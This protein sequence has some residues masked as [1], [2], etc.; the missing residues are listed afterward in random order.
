MSLGALVGSSLL[1]GF[2]QPIDQNMDLFNVLGE[3]HFLILN[4]SFMEYD[5]LRVKLFYFVAF[6]GDTLIKIFK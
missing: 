3:L 2:L 4:Y 5:A 1:S 6:N